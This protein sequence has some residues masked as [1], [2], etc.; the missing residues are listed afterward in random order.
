M[1]TDLQELLKRAAYTPSRSVDPEGLWQRGRRRR[2]L[3]LT[4]SGVAVVAVVTASAFGAV[5][6][7]S[8]G[9]N[10][11]TLGSGSHRTCTA[12]DVDVAGVGWRPNGLVMDG[13]AVLTNDGTSTCSLPR[14]N[15][16][17]LDAEGQPLTS[18]S[19]ASSTGIPV[20][21]LPPSSAVD[22]TPGQ[23]AEATIRW[24]G[25]YC[26]TAD[27]VVLRLMFPHGAI[28]TT[29]VN[30]PVLPCRQ[31][32]YYARGQSS[33]AVSGFTLTSVVAARPSPT[34]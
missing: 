12:A 2:V 4:T 25:S 28:V 27:V 20:D 5:V 11:A 33:A 10:R 19:G 26:G 8:S 21:V 9:D 15:I 32:S 6:L 22:I 16:A 24:G 1:P 3:T 29:P 7:A 17:L 23:S 31:S 13:V 34:S 18:A 14:P 30:G